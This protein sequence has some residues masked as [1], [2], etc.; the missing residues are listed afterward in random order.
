MT[1]TASCPASSAAERISRCCR[2]SPVV[3][4]FSTCSEGVCGCS[5]FSEASI[6]KLDQIGIRVDSEAG[7]FKGSIYA[8]RRAQISLQYGKEE[9]HSRRDNV[10]A[11]ANKGNGSYTNDQSV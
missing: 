8:A 11:S 5:L 9:C 7:G 4:G 2:S 10:W 3:S 1:R 6:V